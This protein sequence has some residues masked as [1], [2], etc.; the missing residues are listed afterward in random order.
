MERE[1][2]RVAAVAAAAALPAMVQARRQSPI[3]LRLMGERVVPERLRT[4]AVAVVVV[5]PAEM[6]W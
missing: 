1:A 4:S 3:P 2:R 6:A 5:A